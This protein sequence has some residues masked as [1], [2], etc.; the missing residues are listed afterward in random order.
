MA[1]TAQMEV[2]TVAIPNSNDDSIRSSKRYL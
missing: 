2:E 1:E